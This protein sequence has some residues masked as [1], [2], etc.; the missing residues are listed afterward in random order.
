MY[1]SYLEIKYLYKENLTFVVS[2]WELMFITADVQH[3][4]VKPL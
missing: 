2:K 1:L 3:P 4:N